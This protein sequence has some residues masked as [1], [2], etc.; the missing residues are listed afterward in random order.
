MI[1]SE[2]LARAKEEGWNR[3]IW[4]RTTTSYGRSIEDLQAAGRHI[5]SEFVDSEVKLRNTGDF[6]NGQSPRRTVGDE[7][8]RERVQEERVSGH[9]DR[10]R[11]LNLGLPENQIGRNQERVGR[12]GDSQHPLVEMFKIDSRRRQDASKH[13]RNTNGKGKAV[14]LEDTLGLQCELE[15]ITCAVA[16]EDDVS[17][18]ARHRTTL[19]DTPWQ[20][21]HGF[22]LPSVHLLPNQR[23]GPSCNLA[24]RT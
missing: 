15:R 2:E 19:A 16:D 10:H 12:I 20:G 4:Q 6:L 8:A 11:T 7:Q 13:R 5:D 17:R 21:T 1:V 9:E 22:S 18:F 14:T 24:P 3:G 23:S